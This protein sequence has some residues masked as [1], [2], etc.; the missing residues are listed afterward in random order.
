MS[1][2]NRFSS[3]YLNFTWVNAEDN[4]H[5]ISCAKRHLRR[6]VDR[7]YF[8]RINRVQANEKLTQDPPI[9]LLVASRQAIAK[10]PRE[11]LNHIVDRAWQAFL[12]QSS[13]A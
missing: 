7:N 9:H 3:R 4:R 6:A 1:T 8:K 11:N 5:A 2:G 10:V 13:A 12:K